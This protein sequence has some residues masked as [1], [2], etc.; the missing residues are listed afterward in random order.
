[1][2]M[3]MSIPLYSSLCLGYSIL[4]HNVT[5]MLSSINM[6]LTIVYDQP[7]WIRYSL[8]LFLSLLSSLLMF[9]FITRYQH[10]AL[11][12][13]ETHQGNI[14]AIISF[15]SFCSY[16]LSFVICGTYCSNKMMTWSHLFGI[17]NSNLFLQPEAVFWI[18]RNL[19]FH[20]LRIS[21]FY[22]PKP[23]LIL[24]EPEVSSIKYVIF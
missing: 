22:G 20:L 3:S 15:S 2:W 7:I 19:K 12:E 11:T 6:G 1:M 16:L 13:H 18:W 23:Y 24:M 9:I 17:Y 4:M 8:T 5:L 21:I 14:I 10:E